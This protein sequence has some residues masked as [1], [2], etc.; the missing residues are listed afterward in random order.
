MRSVGQSSK[1]C[2]KSWTLQQIRGIR[3]TKLKQD[4]HNIYSIICLLTY[5]IS[6]N[7]GDFSIFFCFQSFS[8][9]LENIQEN[10]R[11]FAG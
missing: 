8:K 3:R 4:I 7:Y 1:Q 10:T 5:L 2:L 6:G 9:C 11:D